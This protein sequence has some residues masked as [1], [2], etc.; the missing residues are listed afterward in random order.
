MF[1]FL[2]TTWAIRTHARVQRDKTQRKDIVLVKELLNLTIEN[3]ISK[4]VEHY[5]NSIKAP[6]NAKVLQFNNNILLTSDPILQQRSSALSFL[7]ENQKSYLLKTLETDKHIQTCLYTI[8]IRFFF[9]NYHDRVKVSPAMQLKISKTSK[10]KMDFMFLLYSCLK[11][12]GKTAYNILKQIINENSEIAGFSS[13]E[14]SIP[15]D[16]LESRWI[17]CGK[18]MFNSFL[19]ESEIEVHRSP[20]RGYLVDLSLYFRTFSAETTEFFVNFKRLPLSFLPSFVKENPYNK[21]LKGVELT[22]DTSSIKNNHPGRGIRVLNILTTEQFFAINYLQQSSFR[23]NEDS[24]EHLKILMLG[25][26]PVPDPC[27]YEKIQKLIYPKP[28][29]RIYVKNCSVIIN[30][31][32]RVIKKKFRSKTETYL[33]EAEINKL[34]ML[35]CS[36]LVTCDQNFFFKLFADTRGRIYYN[37]QLFTPHQGDLS[38]SLLGSAKIIEFRP[39]DKNYKSAF[40]ELVLYGRRFFAHNLRNCSNNEILKYFSSDKLLALINDDLIAGNWTQ[41]S[42]NPFQYM[43]WLTELNK[44]LESAKQ[45]TP[46]KTRWLQLIDAQA[47]GL[48]ICC[49]A[50]FSKTNSKYYTDLLEQLNLAPDK[51]IEFDDLPL[52]DIYLFLI[53]K[54]IDYIIISPNEELVDEKNLLLNYLRNQD[55]SIREKE[56]LNSILRTLGKLYLMKLLYGVS[57]FTAIKDCIK[58]LENLNIRGFSELDYKK[59]YLIGR[60]FIR[61]FRKFLAE[62]YLK[63][64]FVFINKLKGLWERIV[65]FSCQTG[66]PLLFRSDKF[67]NSIF[68]YRELRKLRLRVTLVKP[69]KKKV[70]LVYYSST[71]SNFSA[72]TQTAFL[73]NFVH[74]IDSILL[75]GTCITAALDC[76]K[77][78]QRVFITVHDCFGGHL[79]SRSILNDYFLTGIRAFFLGPDSYSHESKKYENSHQSLPGVI[80]FSDLIRGFSSTY[81]EHLQTKE[82][83]VTL[84]E[85]E[86]GDL[87]FVHFIVSNEFAKDIKP[88]LDNL[89][90]KSRLLI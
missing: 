32:K 75:S 7:D 38:R 21:L 29:S 20:A 9:H 25:K 87:Q 13:L 14:N 62:F 1:S 69:F 58:N 80:S 6:T 22:K 55:L 50:A 18:W 33:Y 15:V 49:L 85:E 67:Q 54:F 30:G 57:E 82:K 17:N 66:T 84:S 19:H 4:L 3:R 73:A 28:K 42:K 5:L 26:T 89:L 24:F 72:K 44:M 43:S 41:F 34:I 27:V 86:L 65:E 52:Y 70:D 81:C 90:G 56:N 10:S 39:S 78:R 11:S 74:A 77:T 68:D 8:L 40:I 2:L 64:V 88:L 36:V 83:K 31:K 76:R 23:V 53:L 45:K 63:D 47:S 48:T 61:E 37:N 35:E 16:V 79:L 46:Y 51:N 12:I 60:W 71:S 59:R